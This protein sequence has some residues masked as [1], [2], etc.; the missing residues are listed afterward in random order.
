MKRHAS[1]PE[2]ILC[3]AVVGDPARGDAAIAAGSSEGVHVYLLDGSATVC[4]APSFSTLCLVSVGPQT[5]AGGSSTGDVCVWHWRRKMLKQVLRVSM[6]T[7]AVRGLA[8]GGDMMLTASE[9]GTVR[10]LDV[11]AD[12]AQSDFLTADGPVYCVLR[13][14]ERK[15]TQAA[16]T[17]SRDPAKFG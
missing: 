4:H 3:L 5:L 1:L 17:N 11:L 9:D 2:R 15:L 16:P 12:W 7:A 6:H 8:N 10:K 13:G 14:R